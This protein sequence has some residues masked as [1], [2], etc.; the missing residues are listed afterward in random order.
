MEVTEQVG[1]CTP[2]TLGMLC[3]LQSVRKARQPLQE[4]LALKSSGQ[5]PKEVRL[6][7]CL[8]CSC[9]VFL[10]CSKAL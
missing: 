2:W 5:E 4:G 7:L 10:L 8:E 9:L 3:L 6:L 1:N